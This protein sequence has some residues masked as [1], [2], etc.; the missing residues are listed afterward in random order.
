M[1]CIVDKYLIWTN[2]ELSNFSL[3]KTV[4]S[5]TALLNSYRKNI[6]VHLKIILKIHNWILLFLTHNSFWGIKKSVNDY[7]LLHC[8]GFC[9]KLSLTLKHLCA[10]CGFEY[11]LQEQ[12]N[13][14]R[15]CHNVA[16]CLKSVCEESP[17]F[18]GNI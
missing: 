3:K 7:C 15:C 17:R 2:Y 16:V 4:Q 10:A 18:W 9:S 1:F 11:S 6:M 5:Q 8:F 13:N 14:W 12:A